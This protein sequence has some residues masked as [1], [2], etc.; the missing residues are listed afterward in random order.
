MA[1]LCDMDLLPFGG[2]VKL[3]DLEVNRRMS[4]EIAQRAIEG[5][6]VS[7]HGVVVGLRFR[8]EKLSSFKP[9]I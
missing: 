7:V 5:D 6:I 3:I 9:S 8:L 2:P 4:S 1:G